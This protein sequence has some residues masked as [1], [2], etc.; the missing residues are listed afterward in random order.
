[1]TTTLTE[2]EK[3]EVEVAA[4]SVRRRARGLAARNPLL[5]KKKNFLP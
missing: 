3:V 4:V 5:R 1:M 2:M